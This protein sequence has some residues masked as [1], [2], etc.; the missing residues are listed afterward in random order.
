[1][2]DASQHQSALQHKKLLEHLNPQLKSLVK[3]EDFVAAQ[4]FLFGENFGSRKL[5]AVAALK[6]TVYQQ[7]SRGKQGFQGGYP[8]K[9]NRGE[10]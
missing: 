1:M 2:G 4:P 8:Q 6:K 9:F 10:C 5:E 3:D 7:P